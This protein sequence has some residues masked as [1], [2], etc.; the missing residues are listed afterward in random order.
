MSGSSGTT[1]Y[2]N[3]IWLKEVETLSFSQQIQYDESNTDLMYHKFV[4]RVAGSVHAD[5]DHFHGLD[6][7]EGDQ[8]VRPTTA[9]GA[10]KYVQARLT[11]PRGIF[12]YEVDGEALL[13]A[14]PDPS[15]PHLDVNNGP[16]P[17]AVNV[18][19][20]FG[21]RLLR[22][23]IH[24][25]IC[26]H[27]QTPPL[28]PGGTFGAQANADVLNN[29]WS[30]TEEKDNRWFTVRTLEGTLRVS[31]ITNW[32]HR[33]RYLCVPPL[34]RGYQR[35]RMRFF[36]SP[37]GLTLK[38]QVVDR[39]REAAPPAPAI[40]WE[41]VYTE[42]MQTFGIEAYGEM[43]VK[44][45][46]GPGCDKLLLLMAA[47]NVVYSRLT[48]LATYDPSVRLFS[49]AIVEHLHEPL[50][51]LN[52]RIRHM[53]YADRTLL[54]QKYENFG[55]PMK[56]PG[57]DPGRWPVPS[58]YDPNSPI[59]IFAKYLQTPCIDIHGVPLVYQTD[60]KIEPPKKDQGT[61]QPEVY[62]L[63]NQLPDDPPRKVSNAHMTEGLYSHYFVENEYSYSGGNIAMPIAGTHV[64]APYNT[65]WI[66]QLYKTLCK[67]TIVVHGERAGKWP[68]FPQPIET[69]TDVNGIPHM[70]ASHKITTEAPE[71]LTDGH[72]YLYK[73]Q[74][75]LE[76]F[77]ARGPSNAESFAAGA[78]PRTTATPDETRL[79]GIEVF[80]VGKIV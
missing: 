5:Y 10:M 38:Y 63:P 60:P 77:M 34:L 13:E 72:T 16:K 61:Y 6:I 28:Y 41:A 12:R 80:T 37:D 36:D 59:G 11:H 35:E 76:Y 58:L 26:E 50:V 71:L 8:Y 64:S 45:F 46:G 48:G 51:E 43:Q 33:Y 47:V 21:S 15:K 56:I 79:K 17:V 1:V 54:N 7:I 49:M 78:D 30:I 18:T 40:E 55:Q 66:V 44:L 75:K 25:V 29:R 23:E 53:D 31:N 68:E 22:A 74:M 2:Y 19:Q 57:Y 4:V 20:I 42:S 9:V 65:A 24:T 32:P 62:P 52:C 27:Y 67:R 73:G 70:L 3:G 39:Q 14:Q 69:F